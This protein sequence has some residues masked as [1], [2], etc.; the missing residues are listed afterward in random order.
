MNP[1]FLEVSNTPTTV[2]PRERTTITVIVRDERRNLVP[3]A[4]VTVAAGGGVFLPEPT[5]PIPPVSHPHGDPVPATGL[6]D[7]SG[8]FQTGWVELVNPGAPGYEMDIEASKAGF[9]SG[10]AGLLIRVNR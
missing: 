9:T 6:T 4:R 3:Q 7:H 1:L 2:V 5:T 10:K 8:R